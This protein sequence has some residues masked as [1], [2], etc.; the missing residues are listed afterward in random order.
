MI[1]ARGFSTLGYRRLKDAL[2]LLRIAAPGV[3]RH[4]LSV[5]HTIVLDFEACDKPDAVACTGGGE[6]GVVY[7]QSDPARESVIETACTIAHES[8]HWRQDPYHG[9]IEVSHIES[10][11]T[12]REF[13]RR[14][15]I[16]V[17]EA[18]LRRHLQDL[19]G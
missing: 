2:E 19:V 6:R 7:L 12:V 4:I 15:P 18:S 5:F 17:R 1:Q 10:A 9:L 11:T 16:S 13:F 8:W 3:F 14:D